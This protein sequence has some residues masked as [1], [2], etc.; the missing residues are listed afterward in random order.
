MVNYKEQGCIVGVLFVLLKL[1]F[2]EMDNLKEIL[3][4]ELTISAPDYTQF[5]ISQL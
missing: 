3:T 1:N 2:Y 5:Y 4:Y